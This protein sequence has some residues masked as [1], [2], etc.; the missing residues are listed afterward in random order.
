MSAPTVFL[1]PVPAVIL[2]S[3]SAVSAL[4]DRVAFGSSKQ[5]LDAIPIGI[6]V[7][8]YASLPPHPLFK[9]GVATWT[10]K[11]GA[12][13][14]AVRSGPRSGKHPDPKVRPPVAEQD[15]GPSLYFWEVHG[16]KRLAVPM[17]LDRFKSMSGGKLF[18][19]RAPEWPVLAQLSPE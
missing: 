2:E 6:E 17:P 8:I 18:S 3:A 10:G 13:V 5:G 12:V 4:V 1:A 14:P 11:L 16:L 15:D 9:P 19:G 7:F